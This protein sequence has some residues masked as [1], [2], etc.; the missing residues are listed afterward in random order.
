MK[1]TAAAW[2]EALTH[3]RVWDETQDVPRIR[4]AFSTLLATSAQWPSPSKLIEAMPA[5][6]NHVAL[7]T[8]TLTNEEQLDNL[9]MVQEL[10][11]EALP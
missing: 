1:G 9:K 11:K 7:P 3:N 4:L 2:M 8:T 5:V 6:V 10:L